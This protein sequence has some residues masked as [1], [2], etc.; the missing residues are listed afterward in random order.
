MEE[1]QVHPD[2]PWSGE[3]P[4]RVDGAAK[5]SITTALMSV[6]MLQLFLG[7]VQ[8]TG[9]PGAITT[10]GLGVE[11]EG[12]PNTGSQ[13]HIERMLKMVRMAGE[14]LENLEDIRA[15]EWMG[16]GKEESMSEQAMAVRRGQEE[17][18]VE[19]K[20]RARGS[21]CAHTEGSM[22]F[23]FHFPVIL[24]TISSNLMSVILSLT[25]S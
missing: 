1:V 11:E 2:L 20:Q 16:V 21:G 22:S 23:I 24:F 18:V 6:W 14:E 13:G 25:S 10:R 3:N 5:V 7:R 19:A 17:A 12:S 9:Y 8:R 15:K 4:R